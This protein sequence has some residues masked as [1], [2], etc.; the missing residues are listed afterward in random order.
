[1]K[2]GEVYANTGPV[3]DGFS[4]ACVVVKHYRQLGAFCEAALQ[5]AVLSSWLHRGCSGGV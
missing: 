2:S 3:L 4:S 5:R 1:M